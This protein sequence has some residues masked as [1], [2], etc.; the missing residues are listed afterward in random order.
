[1][2]DEEKRLINAFE[3]KVRKLIF[4]YK[5]QEE[6]NRKL[7]SLI[8]GKDKELEE[9]KA[10][11]S[12]IE[13]ESTNLKLAKIISLDDGEIGRAR[14][15]LSKLVREVDDCIALLDEEEQ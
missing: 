8:A 5:E 13:K 6:E 10:A 12:Q 15:R 4:L 2:T 9:C 1:M 11:F 3:E 14:E 7:R